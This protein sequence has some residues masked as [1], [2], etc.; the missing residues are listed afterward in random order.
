M[1]CSNVLPLVLSGEADANLQAT[2][3]L[4]QILVVYLK[5]NHIGIFGFMPAILLHKLWVVAVG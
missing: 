5:E 2:D 4:S 1:S 3:K